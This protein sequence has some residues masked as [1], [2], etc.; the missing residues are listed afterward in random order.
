MRLLSSL[1]ISLTAALLAISSVPVEAAPTGFGFAGTI[2]R[3][4]DPAGIF[5]GL[6]LPSGTLNGVFTLDP[7]AGTIS[8][9]DG[10]T[11]QRLPAGTGNIAGTYRYGAGAAGDVAGP[12]VILFHNCFVG[13]VFAFQC[14][15][16]QGSDAYVVE[17]PR[18]TSDGFVQSF[19]IALTGG[20]S[21]DPSDVLPPSLDT[22]ET[23]DFLWRFSDG[24][25]V[26]AVEGSVDAIGVIA[27]PSSLALLFIGILSLVARSLSR[28]T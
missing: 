20:A 26:A 15:P 21:I 5:A 9:G 27:E 22:F 23:T 13:S 25:N 11:G 10:T 14:V 7:I 6:P 4:D 16:G 24:E 2:T 1:V 18:L 12:S 3:L 8:F 17:F 19:V 28:R